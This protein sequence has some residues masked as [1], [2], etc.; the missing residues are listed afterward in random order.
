MS[1]CRMQES[2]LRV[3]ALVVILS[4]GGGPAVS[5]QPLIPKWEV[6]YCCHLLQAPKIRAKSYSMFEI[7][8]NGT[9]K[10]HHQ[11]I[12]KKYTAHTCASIYF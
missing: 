10:P 8:K 3:Y 12:H 11:A 9:L 2:D 6:A 4:A 5:L 1:Q 7:V